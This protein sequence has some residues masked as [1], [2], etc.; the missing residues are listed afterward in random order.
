MNGL[1][2]KLARQLI[3]LSVAECAEHIGKVTKRSWEYWE[4][5]RNPIKEDVANYMTMLLERR[6]EII[7]Q[8]ANMG[9]NARKM[10]VVFYKT[11]EHCGDVL[12]W[13]FSQSLARTLA[14]DFGARLVE[15]D[16]Q[17]YKIFLDGF[18]LE[19]TQAHR[20][21]WAAYKAS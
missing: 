18:G 16:Y 8:V 1:E 4:S 6:R 14:L 13:R 20:S 2:L 19:D 15:F 3:G 11:P 17:D 5:E 12:N 9:E 10:A 7:R 21:E